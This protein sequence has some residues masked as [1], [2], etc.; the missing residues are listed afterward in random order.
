MTSISHLAL[1]LFLVFIPLSLVMSQ[2]GD[3]PTG[4]PPAESTSESQVSS[5]EEVS[6]S[7]LLEQEP[8]EVLEE[9]G[10]TV[11]SPDI[12]VIGVSSHE[13]EI[14]PSS[15]VPFASSSQDIVLPDLEALSLTIASSSSNDALPFQL[16]NPKMSFAINE[17]PSFVFSYTFVVPQSAEESTFV[18]EM[19]EVLTDAVSELYEGSIVE[20]IVDVVS[21]VV[22]TVL[23][24]LI[25]PVEGQEPPNEG[26][27]QEQVDVSVYRESEVQSDTASSAPLE[28]RDAVEQDEEAVL[29]VEKIEPAVLESFA[30]VDGK[31]YPLH[32]YDDYNGTFTASIED[33][34]FSV[35]AHT[36]ELHILFEESVHV[37]YYAFTVEGT[38]LTVLPLTQT[39]SAVLVAADSEYQTL[40][41]Q[42]NAS[43]TVH[44]YELLA[45][46]AS[47]ARDSILDFSEGIVFWTTT[48]TASLVG[49]DLASK[50]T[51]SQTLNIKKRQENILELQTGKYD[52]QLE[53]SSIGLELVPEEIEL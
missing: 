33:S 5:T 40:W 26:A 53:G 22:Y 41:L 38:V 50:S 16:V 1:A 10:Q 8:A 42:Q 39:L 6:V 23:E 18:S 49:F 14:A 15:V 45:D 4:I 20:K 48:D 9:S 12:E 46:E 17:I 47:M 2:E 24:V 11:E 37:A 31:R 3:E 7:P 44:S 13:E 29:A 27:I 28:N 25:P 34:V 43:G 30:L 32:I 21:D 51:F 35:G 36:L 52:V 19:A